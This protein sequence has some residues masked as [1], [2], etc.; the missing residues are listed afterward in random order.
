MHSCPDCGSAC[1]CHGDID[2]CVVET[3]AYSAMHCDHCPDDYAWDG[4]DEWE[5]DE[6]DLYHPTW[7]EPTDDVDYGPDAEFMW[8]WCT[9]CRRVEDHVVTEAG[10]GPAGRWVDVRCTGCFAASRHAVADVEASPGPTP[11]ADM[12]AAPD[13]DLPF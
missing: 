7:I 8:A 9:G 12:V 2:D 3:E 6:D 5:D 10:D 11:P 1:Y 13:D 4:D